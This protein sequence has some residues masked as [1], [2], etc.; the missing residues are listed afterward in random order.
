MRTIRARMR[1]GHRVAMAAVTVA[2][3]G[4]AGPVAAQGDAESLCAGRDGCTVREVLDAGI[5]PGGEALSVVSLTLPSPDPTWPCRPTAEEYWLLAAGQAPRLVLELCNDGYGAA[6]V[7]EDFVT[8]SDNRLVHAQA[9]GSAWR[10][11]DT[12]ALQL[13]PLR[14]LEVWEDGFWTIGTNETRTHWDWQR[15]SGQTQWWSPP[16]GDEGARVQDQPE[17]YFRYHPIPMLETDAVKL[18]EDTAL[19]SCALEIGPAAGTGYALWGDDGAVFADGGWMRVAMVGPKELVVS[20]RQAQWASGAQSWLHDDHLELWLGSASN[21]YDQCLEEAGAGLGQWAVMMA[22]GRV[23]PAYGDPVASP[24]LVSR[25]VRSDGSGAVVSLRLMLPEDADGITVVFSK[26][27]GQGQQ[28][29]MVA[30]SQL[31][32]GEAA[33]LGQTTAVGADMTVCAD[34]GGWLEITDSGLS[35]QR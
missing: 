14:L 10:W 25:S 23:I 12:R 4:A 24:R 29:W 9:G 7:G 3:A 16:C 34:R 8:V 15:L 28:R 27:D 33:T 21:Y 22:D 20:V 6:G 5:G 30:T 19:G 11:E 18:G 26:G 13:V 17:S 32:F 35:V 2:L 1:P 31:E